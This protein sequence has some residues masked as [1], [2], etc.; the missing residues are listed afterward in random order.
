M[1]DVCRVAFSFVWSVRWL[2][3]GTKQP[4][5]GAFGYVCGWVSDSLFNGLLTGL[6]LYT[7]SQ[8]YGLHVKTPGKRGGYSLK[9]SPWSNSQT[10]RAHFSNIERV[11]FRIANETRKNQE[12]NWTRGEILRQMIPYFKIFQQFIHIFPQRFFYIQKSL[13][14]VKWRI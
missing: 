3:G 1:C 8:G 11:K 12:I 2:A 6:V 13:D 4:G 7:G 10:P 5:D 9:N 14:F